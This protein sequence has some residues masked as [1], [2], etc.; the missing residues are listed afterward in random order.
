MKQLF[1]PMNP[2]INLFNPNSIAGMGADSALES[3]N[4]SVEQR[5][6]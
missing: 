2:T 5:G 6:G 1:K 4:R 3:N